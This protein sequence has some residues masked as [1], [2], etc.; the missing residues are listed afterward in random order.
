MPG[1]AKRVVMDWIVCLP[2]TYPPQ[3]NS[4]AAVLI[5]SVTVFG[6]CIS[7]ELIKFKQDHKSGPQSNRTGVLIRRG[8]DIERAHAERRVH[9][10]T[11]GEGG[12]LH[13]K[14]RGFRRNSAYW[15]LALGLAGSR[16]ARKQICVSVWGRAD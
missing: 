4:D 1:C 8:R 15:H 11:W 12:R 13:A 9:V 10:R 16:T 7:K 6:D 5:P 14:E 3:P 2:R